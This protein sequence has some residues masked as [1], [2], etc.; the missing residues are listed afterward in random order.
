MATTVAGSLSFLR[1]FV[2]SIC[3]GRGFN[4]TVLKLNRNSIVARIF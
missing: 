4:E 3:F 1:R 2:V